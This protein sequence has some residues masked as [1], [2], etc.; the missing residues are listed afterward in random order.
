MDSR[1]FRDAMGKFATGITVITTEYNEDIS[2]MTVNAFMSVSLEPKLIAISIDEKASMYPK[3][4]KTGKFGL[5]ILA[6]DQKELSM[7]FAKQIKKNREIVFK[8]Q[9][10]VPVIED[11][12]VTL[13]CNVKET[14]EAGD[15]IIFIAEVTDI[16]VNEAEPVLFFGGKYR[17]LKSL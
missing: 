7:I 4:Q 6:E 11:S 3:L 1:L 12:I 14:A 13:S 5:S 10:T 17:S 15:H 8:M 9:D 16:A 2:G